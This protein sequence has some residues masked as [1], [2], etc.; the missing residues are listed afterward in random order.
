VKGWLTRATASAVARGRSLPVVAWSRWFPRSGVVAESHFQG[1][2]EPYPGH[3]R[4]FPAPWPEDL[5]HDLSTQQHVQ[6]GLARLPGLWLAVLKARDVD[7]RSAEDVAQQLGLTRSQEQHILAQ[8]RAA[9]LDHLAELV[10]R[11]SGR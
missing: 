9:L 11:R 3:W 8:A 2:E 1:P 5:S 10:A 6:D 7:R 4:A